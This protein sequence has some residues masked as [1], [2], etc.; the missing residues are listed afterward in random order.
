MHRRRRRKEHRRRRRGGAFAEIN[1][2]ATTGTV[3][4]RNTIEQEPENNG[5][6]VAVNRSKNISTTND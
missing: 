6:A 2:F 3:S 5:N 1:N 4:G